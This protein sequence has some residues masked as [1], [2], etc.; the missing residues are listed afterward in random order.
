MRF[1]KWLAWHQREGWMLKD[2]H[3]EAAIRA[4]RFQDNAWL[5]DWAA[6]IESRKP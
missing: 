3:M 2:I 5:R 4:A 1:L 6:A